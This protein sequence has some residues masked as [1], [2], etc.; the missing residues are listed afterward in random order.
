MLK[1]IAS[2]TEYQFFCITA[3][4]EAL[5]LGGASPQDLSSERIGGFTGVYLGMFAAGPGQRASTPA[6]FDWFDFEVVER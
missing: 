6:D 5:P 3:G 2:P 4:G 1:V